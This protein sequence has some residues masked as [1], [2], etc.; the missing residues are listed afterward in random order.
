MIIAPLTTKSHPYPTRIPLEFKGKEGWIVLD[1]VRMV[2][3]RRL[4]ARMGH[5]RPALVQKVK[6]VIE[7]MLVD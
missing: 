6:A 2:D 4:M 3:K 1:Q 7:E 5:L